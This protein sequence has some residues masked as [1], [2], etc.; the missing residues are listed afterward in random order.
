MK[1]TILS[2]NRAPLALGLSALV[3]HSSSAASMPVLPLAASISFW[4]ALSWLFPLLVVLSVLEGVQLW[5]KAAKSREKEER[6]GEVFWAAAVA[7][8]P[9][10]I[11][12]LCLMFTPVSLP[13]ASS[14][15]F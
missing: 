2:A 13:M 4:T 11:Y 14:L 3:S 8:G 1:N 7:L 12:A 5:K 10:I 6:A 9:A 15:P